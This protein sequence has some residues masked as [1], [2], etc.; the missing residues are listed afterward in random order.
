[1]IAFKPLRVPAPIQC[2]WCTYQ[3]GDSSE[4]RILPWLAQILGHAIETLDITRDA[5][6][7]PYLT[8]A[9]NVDVNWSHSGQVL[10]TALGVG[11]RVGADIEWQRPRRNALA[12][13]ERF[14]APS[15]AAQLRELPETGREVAFTRLW[16]V[17]EA[18]LKAHGHGISYGL[19]R[20]VFALDGEDCRLLHCQGGLGSAQEWAVHSFSPLPGYLAA[21]AWRE[22]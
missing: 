4:A 9:H 14:F 6:G 19:D 20:L 15:E 18:V 7:R 1:M 16:C 5:R 8:G 17:K 12:L 3:R 21:L 11:V 2:A 22:G 13:A 10:L